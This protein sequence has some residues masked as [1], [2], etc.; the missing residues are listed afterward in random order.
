M[1]FAPFPIAQSALQAAN[2]RLTVSANNTANWQTPGFRPQQVSNQER[3]EGGVDSIV[4][5]ANGSNYQPGADLDSLLTRHSFVR[6]YLHQRQAVLAY[7]ANLKSMQTA[8]Q[9]N[10]NLIDVVA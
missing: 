5:Y 10:S 4:H 9:M 2:R 3:K 7:Q 1:V 8:D 6:E